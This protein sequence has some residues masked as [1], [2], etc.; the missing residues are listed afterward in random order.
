MKGNNEFVGTLD[1]YDEFVNMVLSDAYEMYVPPL[2]SSSEGIP[3]HPPSSLEIV[4]VF[5]RFLSAHFMCSPRLASRP[6]SSYN[7]DGSRTVEKLGR[8]LVNGSHVTMLVPGSDGGITEAEL[9][10]ADE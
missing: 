1:G 10:A 7:A 9:A 4:R 6:L 3:K 8:A 2:S 5:F